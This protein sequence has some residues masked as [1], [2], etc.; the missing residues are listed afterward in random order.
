[1]KA[2]RARWARGADKVASWFGLELRGTDKKGRARLPLHSAD[3]TIS[4]VRRSSAIAKAES[5][6]PRSR[7]AFWLHV[8]LSKK[9]PNTIALILDTDTAA[10]VCAD[11]AARWNEAAPRREYIGDGAHDSF[12][13]KPKPASPS[14]S[15][16]FRIG[17]TSS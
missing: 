3:V 6:K 1:M 16:G 12:A 15:R 9:H 14:D 4:T 10:Q 8:H 7:P 5:V 17:G 11:L 13:V 2:R